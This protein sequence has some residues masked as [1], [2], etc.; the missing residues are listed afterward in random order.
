MSCGGCPAVGPAALVLA[1]GADGPRGV[2]RQVGHRHCLHPARQGVPG[3]PAVS[4]IRDIGLYR[5]LGN[6]WGSGSDGSFLNF[7]LGNGEGKN[8]EK[9]SRFP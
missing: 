9:A 8:L 4:E 7:V 3:T 1:G 6:A 5:V 2:C